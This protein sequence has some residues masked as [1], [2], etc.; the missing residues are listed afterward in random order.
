[1]TE[2]ILPR[3]VPTD[4]VDGAVLSLLVAAETVLDRMGDGRLLE[5]TNALVDEMRVVLVLTGGEGSLALALAWAL[6]DNAFFFFVADETW[7]GRVAECEI[8]GGVWID[9]GEATTTVRAGTGLEDNA[10]GV[11][12]GL[13][14]GSGVMGGKG[15]GS[16]ANKRNGGGGGGG[17]T[18]SGS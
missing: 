3:Q 4:A 15:I 7:G 8:R 18:F 14:E 1:V 16:V 9:E 13:R 6:E 2:V 17:A 5:L 10:R 11:A 12:K